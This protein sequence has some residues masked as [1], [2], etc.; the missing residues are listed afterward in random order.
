MLPIE[1]NIFR[2]SQTPLLMYETLSF[3]G[4]WGSDKDHATMDASIEQEVYEWLVSGWWNE[5][6]TNK[7]IPIFSVFIMPHIKL[8]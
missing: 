6:V 8:I 4:I 7:C 2:K 5:E 3:R 1:E